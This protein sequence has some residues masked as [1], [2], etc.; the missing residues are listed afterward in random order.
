MA[1]RSVNDRFELETRQQALVDHALREMEI[2]KHVGRRHGGESS[3]REWR[4]GERNDVSTTG[5]GCIT[6]IVTFLGM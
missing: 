6:P 1:L 2:V 5:S 3:A 4:G